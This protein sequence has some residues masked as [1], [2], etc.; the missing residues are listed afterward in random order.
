MS[1]YRTGELYIYFNDK[2]IEHTWAH[3][4]EIDSEIFL[5]EW[6]SAFKVVGITSHRGHYEIDVQFVKEPTE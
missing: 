3:L 4:P 6:I 2:L 5:N 1:E